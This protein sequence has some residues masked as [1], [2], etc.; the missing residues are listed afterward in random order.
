MEEIKIILERQREFYASGKTKE[1]SYRLMYLKRLEKSIHNHERDILAALKKD[2][3]KAPFEAYATEI[4]IVLSELKFMMR[5]LDRWA[6]AKRIKTTIINQIASSKVYFE[7]Y[8]IAL[9][10]SP[11]NYPFQLTMEPLIGAIAA[12]NCAVV[13]P[14]ITSPNTSQVIENILKE[15]FPVFYVAVIQGG[16]EANQS[17]L[18][19]KFDYIFFTGSPSVG[20][21]VMQAA[22]RN[23]T[24]V[25]M[26]LG[27]KSPCIV[28]ETADISL[29]AKRIVWGKFTNAGQTCVAPDYVLVQHSV[30]EA[31]LLKMKEYIFRFYGKNPCNNE[32]YP[33][34]I[35]EK[36]FNRLLGLLASGH[37]VIG[38]AA[39]EST[40]QIAPTILDQIT[41]NSKVME[42]EIF[43]PI[44]PV[45]EY[46]NLEDV[47]TAI[48]KRPKPLALYLFTRS[49]DN[50]R[51]IIRNISFGGGCINDTLMHLATSYMPFGG[52]GE[53]GMGRYHGKASFETFSHQK[54]I[55]KK[56][57]CFDFPFRYP[58]YGKRLDLA[59]KILK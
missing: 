30:K 25:T 20:K 6:G 53:S 39:S 29:A 55:L 17:L 38:G 23:L 59:K 41:W 49:K 33:K 37:I 56:C 22:A 51:E 40:R 27:G 12:G 28:D 21:A 35:N 13:K 10:M 43:G 32:N 14:S 2:L 9:I 19:Q 47:I 16:R 4:G 18:E 54:S 11:W 1:L 44:L 36:H 57:N 50:E 26:E 34:I 8:G 48:S 15:V 7:P 31:L 52:V 24:P 3:N 5:N 58:P 46:E 45:I 42:E